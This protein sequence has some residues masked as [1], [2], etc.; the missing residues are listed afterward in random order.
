MANPLY[1]SS[2]AG[3][4]ITYWNYTV[5]YSLNGGRD[6]V[7]DALSSVMDSMLDVK[8]NLLIA[9]FTHL[10]YT[11]KRLLSL[12]AGTKRGDMFKVLAAARGR[13]S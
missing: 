10:D 9:D 8:E 4:T 12:T 6:E 5:H 1:L 11:G 13:V 7:W 3:S 2:R